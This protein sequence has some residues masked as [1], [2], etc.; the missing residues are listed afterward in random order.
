MTDPNAAAPPPDAADGQGGG[1]AAPGRPYPSTPYAAYLPSPYPAYPSSPAH[2]PTPYPAYPPSPYPAYPPDGY[3]GYGAGGWPGYYPA[4]TAQSLRGLGL[5]TRILLAVQ[6]LATL[7][8]VFPALHERTLISRIRSDPTSVSLADARHADHVFALANGALSLLYLASAVLWIIW[9]YRA[10]SN[11][12]AWYPSGPDGQNSAGQ[13]RSTGWAIGAWFCPIV[14]LWFPYTIAKDI[15][16][17]T[18]RDVRGGTA[19]R[20]LLGWWW[21]LFVLLLVLGL[22]QSGERSGKSLDQLSTYTDTVVVGLVVRIVGLVLAILVVAR[23]TAAQS[24]RSERRPT[25]PPPYGYGAPGGGRR[26]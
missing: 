12:N 16:D 19:R 23:I 22:A 6:L 24:A 15:L 11:I 5:A 4:P 14:N 9:F 17:A 1:W 21:A 18:E 10:R 25:T 7:A 3:G 26:H 8:T 2:P 20:P 13:R